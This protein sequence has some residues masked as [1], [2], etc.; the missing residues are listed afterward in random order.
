MRKLRQKEIELDGQ[1]GWCAV[2]FMEL[3]AKCEQ[4][5]GLGMIVTAVDVELPKPLHPG[6]YRL[7]YVPKANTYFYDDK[8]KFL[9]KTSGDSDFDILHI[10]HAERDGADDKPRIRKGCATAK[11]LEL[12]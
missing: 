10:R 4:L 1:G 12:M 6:F 9:P 2:P 8:N 3:S 5:T 7:Y 11:Q